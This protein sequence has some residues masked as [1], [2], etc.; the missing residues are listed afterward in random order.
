MKKFQE[1]NFNIEWFI[2]R[3]E[4]LEIPEDNHKYTNWMKSFKVRGK[5]ENCY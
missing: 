3:T 5:L 4:W 2:Q 1:S